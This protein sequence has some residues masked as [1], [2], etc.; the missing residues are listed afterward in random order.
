MT[1][2]TTQQRD[3]T[4]AATTT[5]NGATVMVCACA[6]EERARAA[7]ESLIAHLEKQKHEQR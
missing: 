2:T 6:T 4:W 5:R 3:G 7:L 1:I